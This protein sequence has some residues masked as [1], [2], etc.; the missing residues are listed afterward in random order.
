[1]ATVPKTQTLCYYGQ[2][3]YY[4]AAGSDATDPD[5]DA[6]PLSLLQPRSATTAAPTPATLL[7]LPLVTVTSL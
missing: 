5:T 4:A 1:M 2:S 3:A 6:P 7:L